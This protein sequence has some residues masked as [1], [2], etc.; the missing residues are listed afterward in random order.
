MR[1]PQRLRI[2]FPILLLLLSLPAI[3]VAEQTTPPANPP[4]QTEPIVVTVSAQAIPLSAVSAS[5]TVITR[6]MIER[7]RAKSIAEL[8]TETGFVHI[9]QT[10]GAG[11]LTT[12][13]LRGG[14]PNFTMV[15][16]DGIPLNDPTNILGG[17]Y[18]LSSLS[19]DNVEQIEI[20]RGPLSSLYGSEAVSGVLNIISR[21]GKGSALIDAEV[22]AGGFGSH[23]V[24][25]GAQGEFKRFH[26]AMSGSHFGIDE[27]V[28]SDSHSLG[29]FG[30]SGTLDI[31][32]QN[33]LHMIARYNNSDSEGFPENGGGPLF[34]ILRDPKSVH[35]QEVVAGLRYLHELNSNWTLNLDA[36]FYDRVQDTFTPAIL[37]ATPPSPRSLPP[38]Q[39][40]TDFQR[41]RFQWNNQFK[42]GKLSATA[43]VG[44]KWETG[45][46]V[47]LIADFLPADF[48]LDRWTTF[49]NGEVLYLSD[50]WDFSAGIRADN[51]DDFD[52]EYSPH[53]AGSYRFLQSKTRLKATWGEGYKL[54]SFLA[55]GDPN[56]GNPELRP[57][58]SRGFDAG[59]E[60]DD[61]LGKLF[62]S[63]TYYQNS[64]RDLIDFSP[65]EFR[66]V[67]RRLV[68]TKGVEWEGR[69]RVSEDSEVGAH[70]S[71]LDADIKNSEEPLRDR[72]KWRGG[73]H[74]DW[75][76]FPSSRLFLS[77]VWVGSR[78]D[79]QLPVP[80]RS[81]ADAYHAVN[82]A[83]SQ[84]ISRDFVLYARVDNLL[85]SD[86]QE[87]IG[88]PNPGR[89]L[90]AGLSY[91]F[92]PS[93]SGGQ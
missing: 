54:P 60:Q 19:T 20:V 1:H 3:V 85:D 55:L 9:S 73:I 42:V 45:E 74:F 13:T 40:N 92:I 6:E 33:I 36:D 89:Y 35:A 7:S 88:F 28:E 80:E 70:L 31:D 47:G 84:N 49:F 46:N 27:Q 61:I 51:S 69:L 83:F 14:D 39:S 30:F 38:I 81:V 26:Y 62:L 86:Y 24:R 58:R 68:T 63:V 18:D 79:F 2:R 12:L 57:E 48:S 23:F 53:V 21:R 72:P 66:L 32:Q 10:G 93:G 29:T 71:Y 78:F 5:V 90:R 43:G 17:S 15:L 4:A 82:V 25:A 67:N 59:I 44:G 52:P 91:R 50:Q 16:V 41:S 64:F 34:S 76:L 22:S 56:I 11:G 65:E 8:L 37:D 75:R 87:F 77:A